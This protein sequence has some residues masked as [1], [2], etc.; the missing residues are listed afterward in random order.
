MAQRALLWDLIQSNMFKHIPIIKDK[1]CINGLCCRSIQ[2][3]P[4]STC[5]NT[6]QFILFVL[7]Y[8]IYYFLFLDAFIN[9][10]LYW[11]FLHLYSSGHQAVLSC[12]CHAVFVTCIDIHYYFVH[13]RCKRR[14][15]ISAL[16]YIHTLSLASCLIHYGWCITFG[17]GGWLDI[18]IKDRNIY[19][20][21]LT[22][23]EATN[24]DHLRTYN[25]P[26]FFYG[27]VNCIE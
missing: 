12:Y 13:H 22:F 23:M 24:S 10:W 6:K 25:R 27:Y 19:V 16:I 3:L 14:S 2:Q 9:N 8:F 15:I 7:N 4:H 17:R 20:S 18:H 1:L 26:Q 5:I 11:I 21:P